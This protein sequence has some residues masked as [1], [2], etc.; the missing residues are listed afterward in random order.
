MTR[1]REANPRKPP[2]RPPTASEFGDAR[3]TA[4]QSSFERRQAGPA[5][6]WALWVLHA[7][8]VEVARL[9]LSEDLQ[10]QRDAVAESIL[11]VH[12][13][14]VGRGFAPLTV[15]PLMR[16]V[17][18]LA[19]RENGNLDYLFCERSR[20]GRPKATMSEHERTGVLAALATFWLELNRTSG[21]RQN[22]LLAEAARKMKGPWFGTVTGSNLK[23]ARDLVM[24][25]ARD[26]P[27]VSEAARF[28]ADAIANARASF[29]DREAWRVLI[30]FLNDVS[31]SHGAV[32]RIAKTPRITP[33]DDG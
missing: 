18:A 6:V 31:A 29:G 27:A 13:Y 4:L 2:L 19:E 32:T 9:Y 26:H 17:A 12:D 16:T 10:D 23:T 11:A 33:S 8:M 24:Q 1:K 22:E 5:P 28:T 7:R 15:A 21:R 14:L 3:D 20:A 30:Q 25:E